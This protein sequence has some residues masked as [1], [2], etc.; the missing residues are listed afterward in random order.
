MTT[1]A[2]LPA[3]TI[4]D[5]AGDGE[6]KKREDGLWDS[7]KDTNFT[8]SSD[9]LETRH[10]IIESLP[11]GVAWQLAILLGDEYGHTD[12]EGEPITYEGLVE[13]A[14]DIHNDVLQRE[15]AGKEV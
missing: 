7:T 14:I 2:K 1:F 10:V 3:K 6:F 9:Y 4:I 8:M 5:V 15:A 12:A 11:Y 13:Q